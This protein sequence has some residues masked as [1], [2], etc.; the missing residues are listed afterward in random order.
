MSNI[1]RILIVLL[2]FQLVIPVN[3]LLHAQLVH[4]F[5]S[6]ST[7]QGLSQN[8]VQSIYCDDKGSLWFGTW[9]GLNRY[10]GYDF[11]IFHPFPGDSTSL[12]NN[13][14]YVV[15]EDH[16]GFIWI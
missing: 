9:D 5:E 6:I 12:T 14:L 7:A 4:K 13:D 8:Y 2:F 10:D 15:Y 16:D 1:A 3:N 11:K